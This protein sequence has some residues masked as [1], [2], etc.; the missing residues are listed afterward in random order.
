MGGAEWEGAG[1]VITP[2]PVT[3]I[4][5]PC[6]FLG[7]NRGEGGGGVRGEGKGREGVLYGTLPLFFPLILLPFPLSVLGSG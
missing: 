1:S 7:G 3:F 2:T 4:T 5:W 6:C